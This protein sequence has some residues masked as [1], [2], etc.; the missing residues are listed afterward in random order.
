MM[1]RHFPNTVSDQQ[2]PE[3]P[4]PG[5]DPH[6][7]CSLLRVALSGKPRASQDG[8]DPRQGGQSLPTPVRAR[9]CTSRTPVHRKVC[10]RAESLPLVQRDRLQLVSRLRSLSPSG[11]GTRCHPVCGG[12]SASGARPWGEKQPDAGARRGADGAP[13]LPAR[14]GNGLDPEPPGHA[15]APVASAPQTP[16]PAPSCC[17]RS[18]WVRVAPAG[19]GWRQR[20]FLS[21]MTPTLNPEHFHCRNRFKQRQDAASAARSRGYRKYPMAGAGRSV[22]ER[23]AGGIMN[24]RCRD[25][26]VGTR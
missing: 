13:T 23:A 2:T 9:V 24:W 5:P 14:L 18:A 22:T 25:G 3:H 16:P 7:P 26:A 17:A 19:G 12:S 21:R 11:T 10:R 8:A 15:P 6:G 4:A 1:V 20:A